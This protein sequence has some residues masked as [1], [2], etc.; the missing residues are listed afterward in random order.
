MRGGLFL[1]LVEEGG[2][3]FFFVVETLAHAFHFFVPINFVRTSSFKLSFQLEV[4]FL[5]RIL[6]LF[7]QTLNLPLQLLKLR[8]GDGRRRR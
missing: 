4:S 5:L 3:D 8:D 6:Q 7:F 2:E 1:L